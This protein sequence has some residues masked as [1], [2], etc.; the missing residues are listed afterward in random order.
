MGW[1][2]HDS[3]FPRPMLSHRM[4]AKCEVYEQKPQGL[5]RPR[6]G[7]AKHHFLLV[8]ANHEISP[9]LGDGEVDSSSP[10]EEL[11][12]IRVIFANYCEDFK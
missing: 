1:R 12:S 9:D 3:L 8:R 10:W 11:L 4:A 7:S 6:S 2:V 5:L